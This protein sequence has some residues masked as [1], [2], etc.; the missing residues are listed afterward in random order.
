MITHDGYY[1]I[2]VF[3]NGSASLIEAS[4]M[5][6]SPAIHTGV[7]INHLRGDCVGNTLTLYVN[8]QQIQ[9]VA[10]RQDGSLAQGDVGLLAGAFGQPG[11]DMFFD[12]FVVI[13][14]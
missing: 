9:Q 10:A 7:N 1:G 14:P 2:G 13:Q 3:L 6:F 4:E 5:Q 12:N 11:V 8:G